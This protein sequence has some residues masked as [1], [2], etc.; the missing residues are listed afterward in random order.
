MLVFTKC[1]TFEKNIDMKKN[2][3]LILL[4][5]SSFVFAQKISGNI[6]DHDI[7]LFEPSESYGETVTGIFSTKY[8]P[9]SKTEWNAY[10]RIFNIGNGANDLIRSDA[11]TVYKSGLATLPSVNNN[12]ISA[13]ES[14]RAIITKE[15]LDIRIPKPPDNGNYSLESY[16]GV[17]RW[18][19]K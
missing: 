18:V 13:D 2:V 14:G 9:V 19:K 16:N 4:L 7:I 11:L 10:D 17:V 1:I 6:K 12:L 15:F 3:L 8:F 5:G